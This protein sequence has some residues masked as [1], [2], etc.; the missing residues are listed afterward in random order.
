MSKSIT[1]LNIKNVSQ[2]G[3]SKALVSGGETS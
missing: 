1:T 2:E 3:I